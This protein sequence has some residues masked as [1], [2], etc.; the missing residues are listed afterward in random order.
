M[1]PRYPRTMTN[2]S[3]P[4]AWAPRMTC[5]SSGLPWSCTSG[6]GSSPERA[7]RRLP[8]PAARIRAILVLDIFDLGWR[9]ARGATR[10]IRKRGIIKV[11]NADVGAVEDHRLGEAC[12]LDRIPESSALVILLDEVDT[13]RPEGWILR[14]LAFGAGQCEVFGIHP[15]PSTEQVLVTALGSDLNQVAWPAFERLHPD[16][17]KLIVVGN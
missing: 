14:W 4:A 12:G 10:G 11:A 5:S 3:I 17:L 13:P 8:L 7:A 1:C 2:L 16:H 15:Y 9:W 6:L